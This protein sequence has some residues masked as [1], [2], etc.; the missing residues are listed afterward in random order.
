LKIN[1]FITFGIYIWNQNQFVQINALENPQKTKSWAS[2][3]DMSIPF[4]RWD[5]VFVGV[6]F[7]GP[8][9]IHLCLKVFVLVVF[10]ASV[11]LVILTKRRG[12]REGYKINNTFS[13]SNFVCI[14]LL[15]YE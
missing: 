15:K 4:M 8:R 1:I 6:N 11:S 3:Y 5:L 2:R 13:S 12:E 9:T 10:I 14:L 7:T